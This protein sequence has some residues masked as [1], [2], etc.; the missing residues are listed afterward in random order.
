MSSPFLTLMCLDLNL[1]CAFLS[2][3][4]CN[5][6]HGLL[7]TAD[8]VAGLFAGISFVVAEATS[9]AEQSSPRFTYS[10]TTKTI[11]APARLAFH[12]C[13]AIDLHGPEAASAVWDGPGFPELLKACRCVTRLL[14]FDVYYICEAQQVSKGHVIS[15]Y[16]KRSRRAF[17][18][19][20]QSG[21]RQPGRCPHQGDPNEPRRCICPVSPSQ[22][23]RGIQQDF[24]PSGPLCSDC[25]IDPLRVRALRG[26]EACRRAEADDLHSMSNSA[27]LLHHLPEVCAREGLANLF[28]RYHLSPAV[29]SLYCNKVS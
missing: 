5:G 29:P 7:S 2:Q 10:P 4:I 1:Y 23:C 20:V 18:E 6:Q 15:S 3:A 27:V 9:P 13:C 21:E 28:A 24:K 14:C 22:A 11:T 16:L 26:R 19:I 12:L 25:P 17:V 8:L